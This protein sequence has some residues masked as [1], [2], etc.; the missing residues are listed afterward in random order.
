[1]AEVFYS[2]IM[3]HKLREE[4]RETYQEVYHYAISDDEIDK[5][6]SPEENRHS[7]GYDLFV[8]QKTGP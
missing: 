4:Y 6:L 5:L 8:R 3:S 1:M 7:A 2:D